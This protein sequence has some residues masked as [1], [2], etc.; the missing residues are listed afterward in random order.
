[1]QLSERTDC[2]HL[3]MPTLQLA[4]QLSG[5]RFRVIALRIGWFDILCDMLGVRVESFAFHRLAGDLGRGGNSF[6]HNGPIR[7]ERTG[8]IVKCLLTPRIADQ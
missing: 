6:S 1:M 5:R 8:A 7:R 2:D 3:Q 4:F